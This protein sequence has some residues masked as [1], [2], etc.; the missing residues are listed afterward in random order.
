MDFAIFAMLYIAVNQQ[1]RK[2]ISDS[3][4]KTKAWMGNRLAL[5]LPLPRRA[6]LTNLWTIVDRYLTFS[7][8]LYPFDAFSDGKCRL[9]MHRRYPFP[10]N[11]V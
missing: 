5:P 4:L 10:S 11:A 9:I 1:G 3:Y 7:I 2:S 8:G 6:M